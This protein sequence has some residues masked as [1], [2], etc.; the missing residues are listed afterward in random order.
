MMRRCFG[1]IFFGDRR[2]AASGAGS[3]KGTKIEVVRRGEI[4]RGGTGLDS[5]HSGDTS[6]FH[7]VSKFAYVGFKGVSLLASGF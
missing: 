3:G 5:E 6:L 4:L 1:E 2:K 7:Y